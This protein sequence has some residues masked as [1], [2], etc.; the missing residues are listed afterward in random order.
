MRRES[1]SERRNV[2]VA[3]RTNWVIFCTRSAGID[4]GPTSMIHLR[5]PSS[6]QTPPQPAQT[7][8]GMLRYR[9]GLRFEPHPEQNIVP[10]PPPPCESAPH[11]GEA[12]FHIR[13][14]TVS[15]KA[16]EWT[17]PRRLR[18][19]PILPRRGGHAFTPLRT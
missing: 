19:R 2:G 6:S 3:V 15:C 1:V 5:R 11:P 17:W 7:S 8:I 14:D 10:P 18:R 9:S 16:F 13:P 12:P 4:F